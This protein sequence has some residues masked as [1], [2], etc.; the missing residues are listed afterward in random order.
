MKLLFMSPGLSKPE[1]E[2]RVLLTIGCLMASTTIQLYAIPHVLIIETIFREAPHEMA[3]RV[4]QAWSALM[5][6]MV[7][8]LAWAMGFLGLA[9]CAYGNGWLQRF[10][11]KNQVAMVEGPD[12]P[13]RWRVYV[14]AS[15]GVFIFVLLVGSWWIRLI[16]LWACSVGLFV[17]VGIA[18]MK[19]WRLAK[20]CG[21]R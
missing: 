6:P 14:L 18:W 7:R 16:L 9:L 2:I 13:K 4:W 5:I 8:P 20:S 19:P 17:P 10:D 1:R 11:P 15:L 3:S 21:P 12:I